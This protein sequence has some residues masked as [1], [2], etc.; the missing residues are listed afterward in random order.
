MR[1]FLL[2]PLLPIFAPD[3]APCNHAPPEPAEAFEIRS[4]ERV[5]DW[6][7]RL[8]SDGSAVTC[9]AVR[10]SAARLEPG[11]EGWFGLLSGNG[12]RYEFLPPPIAR[13][14]RF[15]GLFVPGRYQR[16]ADET[17]DDLI[18]RL[19]AKTEA[20]LRDSPR[21]DDP[22]NVPGLEF[23]GYRQM[24]LASIVEKEAASNRDYERVAAVFLN[25]LRNNEVLGSCPTVEYALGYHRPFL[26]Y[27][28]L[29]LDSPYNV[30]KRRGLPPTPI[31]FFSDEAFEAFDAVRRPIDSADYYFVYDW[32][33]GELVFAEDYSDHRRN[34]ELARE[35]F[36]NRFGKDRLYQKY[37]DLFYE[38][39]GS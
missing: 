18:L 26:L 21:D 38:L 10:R 28:D 15:E 25:R 22:Y 4:G 6:C 13:L 33:N 34:S 31:A 20:R 23:T 5:R 30:Y 37:E 32:T 17:V 7:E 3:F 16:R 36:I 12:N 39:P 27:E 24:T 35:R 14:N 29:K 19:L 8:E 11:R 2:L 9:A 1:L